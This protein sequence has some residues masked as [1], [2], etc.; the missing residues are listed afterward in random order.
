[1]M[2]CNQLFVYSAQGYRYNAEGQV[3]AHDK[4]LKRISGTATLYFAILT[5]KLPRDI[6]TTPPPTLLTVWNWLSSLL[7]LGEYIKWLPL[8]TFCYIR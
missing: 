7:N 6:N 5:A 2:M 4:F 1:M 8:Y 3:E